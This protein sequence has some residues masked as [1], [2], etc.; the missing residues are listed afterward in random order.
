MADLRNALDDPMEPTIAPADFQTIQRQA[1]V[2]DVR[3][4]ADYDASAEIVPD[5]F[6]KDPE[7]MQRWIGALPKTHEVVVYCVRGGA[8][9]Q[10]IAARLRDEGI[11]ARYIVGGLQGYKAAGGK[12]AAKRMRTSQ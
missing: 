5:A 8:L 11:K 12:L 1:L 9:S 4:K 6:W 7:Q 2:L 10:D 3:R